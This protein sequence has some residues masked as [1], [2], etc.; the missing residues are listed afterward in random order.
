MPARSKFPDLV[1]GVTCKNL[2][3]GGECRLLTILASEAEDRNVGDKTADHQPFMS[4]VT[5][6]YCMAAF[7]LARQQL[8]SEFEVV[9]T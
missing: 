4:N 5:E 9:S 8:C 3:A 2:G 1:A 6:R 7:Y